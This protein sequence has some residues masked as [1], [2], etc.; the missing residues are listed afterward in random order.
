M[1]FKE[2]IL[3]K[4][5]KNGKRRAGEEYSFLGMLLGKLH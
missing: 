4:R 5:K 3:S 1:E 2:K